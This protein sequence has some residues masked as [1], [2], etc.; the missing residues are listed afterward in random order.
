MIDWYSSTWI[1][2]IP[3]FFDWWYGAH[4]EYHFI[5]AFFICSIASGVSAA[6]DEDFT[7]NEHGAVLVFVTL[8]ST[9]LLALL[10]PM[11]I[12]LLMVFAPLFGLFATSVGIPYWTT[13]LINRKRKKT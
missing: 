9:L 12:G 10:V 5:I 1:P 2:L 6:T 4:I 7:M 8:A 11:I 13:K 3:K